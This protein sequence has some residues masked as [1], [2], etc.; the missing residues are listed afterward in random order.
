MFPSKLKKSKNNSEDSSLSPQIFGFLTPSPPTP[1][2]PKKI[3]MKRRYTGE[4]E[5]V[6]SIKIL[7]AENTCVGE[8]IF[9]V[10]IFFLLFVVVPP[11]LVNLFSF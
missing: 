7:S 9:H 10:L 3:L 5:T 11:S 4:Q 6:I 2:P 1:H 8:T